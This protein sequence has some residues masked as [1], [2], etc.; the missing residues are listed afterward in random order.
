M[1]FSICDCPVSHSLHT[2]TW[3]NRLLDLSLWKQCSFPFH[4]CGTASRLMSFPIVG[5]LEIG[6]CSSVLVGYK[7]LQISTLLIAFLVF[8]NF[9]KWTL[10]KAQR[11][12]DKLGCHL[13]ICR[14]SGRVLHLHLLLAAN[15]FFVINNNLNVEVT[16]FVAACAAG[17]PLQDLVDGK[18]NDHTYLFKI[19]AVSTVIVI[20]KMTRSVSFLSSALP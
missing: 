10:E 1:R 14:Q 17:L 16:L 18:R 9:F 12:P 7:W 20:K 6:N 13:H 3:D 19:V 8:T 2:R 5:A 15:C 11:L 4:C